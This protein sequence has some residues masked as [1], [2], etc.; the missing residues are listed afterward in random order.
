M[1]KIQIMRNGEIELMDDVNYILLSS[2]DLER[3]ETLLFEREVT[4]R[5]ER[6]Q[7]ASSVSD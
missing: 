4:R 6:K 3:I 5:H 2:S 7:D 1:T